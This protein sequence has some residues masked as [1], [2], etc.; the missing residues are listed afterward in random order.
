MFDAGDSAFV[1]G[2]ELTMID[3]NDELRCWIRQLAATVNP[4]QIDEVKGKRGLITTLPQ[5][6][7]AN[8]CPRGTT[9][10]RRTI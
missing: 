10:P 8:P 7:T 4:R 9:Q 1:Q 5:L 3:N 2:S 6:P